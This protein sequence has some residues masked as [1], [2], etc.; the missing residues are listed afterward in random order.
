MFGNFLYFIVALLIYTTY[1][2][3]SKP[4]LSFFEA[5]AFFAAITLVFTAVTTIS[6]KRLEKSIL[7]NNLPDPE[8]AFESLLVRQCI[9]ATGLF[10]LHIYGLELSGHI[11]RLSF[12][13]KIPTIGAVLFL[14]VF[15]GYLSIVWAVAYDAHEILYRSGIGRSRYIRSHISF[16]IPVLLPWLFLSLAADLIH[17]LP[18]ETPRSFLDSPPGQIIYFLFFLFAIAI[19]GPS[20]IQYFWGCRPLA[21]GEART[22]I[23]ELCKKA[24][25]SY[26]EILQWPLFGGRT[27]TAGVMGLAGRFRY[28]LVT[29]ALIRYL[30]P[31]EVKAVI[32]HEIGHVHHHHLLF[33]LL[34]F[35]GYLL[36]SFA[37]L[38]FMIY[39]AVYLQVIAG[40][41]AAGSDT[42]VSIVLSVTM[43]ATF[44]IYF[45][46]GFGY[47]MRNFER[48]ADISVYR[49]MDSAM[50]LIS[51]F[52]KIAA[53]SRQAPDKPNWHH[54]SISER[55]EYLKKCQENPA[56][57]FRHHKKVKASIAVYVLLMLA[58]AG[59]GYSWHFGSTGQMIAGKMTQQ[60]L[61]A[62]LL[63]NPQNPVLNL[64]TA[65]LL[66]SRNN[67]KAAEAAYLKTLKLDPGNVQALNN[68]A[69][70]YATS[71]PETGFFKPEKALELATKAFQISSEPHVTDT[72][73]ESLFV[74]GFYRQ[75]VDAGKKALSAAESN[76]DYYRRQLEKFKS[77]LKGHSD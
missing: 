47:F 43:I 73:A 71:T 58:V 18:F 39:S 14:A 76:K 56:W 21:P 9:I 6:F 44:F 17:V 7:K 20:V 32:A 57:I 2:P 41:K 26:R 45:R 40:M 61:S 70:M 49:L 51:T 64:L 24:G 16:S 1:P 22:R 15:V 66:Y 13:D 75:A 12:V 69:W 25:V 60:L 23:E 77:G 54:F 46:F 50:P 72:L 3:P 42:F 48:Q 29:P 59:F 34:F 53:S 8:Q 31:A 28:I 55:I 38:D 33:Y 11:H 5:F 19:F 36:I 67:L 65:D 37:G 27:I 63:Q 52:H 35:A 10:A 74:N 68:L 62:Q 30:T 4:Q